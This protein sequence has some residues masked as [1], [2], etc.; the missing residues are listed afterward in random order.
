MK[1]VAFIT[2]SFHKIT[3]SANIYAEEIFNKAHFLVTYF[4][5]EDWTLNPIG[6]NETIIGYDLVV[7]TQLISLEILS[8]IKCDNVV[9]IPMYDFSYTWDIFKWLECINLKILS[10]TKKIHDALTTMGL[11]SYY[12]KYYPEPFAYKPGDLK[13]IFLWQ[14][15]NTINVKSTLHLLNNF[16]IDQIYLHKAID[17]YQTFVEP[18]QQ[19]ISEYN[20]IFSDW[21]E[22]KQGYIEIL[23]NIGIY[24]APRLMEGGASAFIDAMKMGKVVIAN[25]DAAMNEY[26]THNENGLLYDASCIQPI[27]F[28]LIDLTQIQKNAYQSVKEGRNTWLK[29]IP[30]IL[31][32]I[33][34]KSSILLSSKTLNTIREARETLRQEQIILTQELEKLNH[35]KW[36]NFGKLSHQEKIKKVFKIICNPLKIINKPKTI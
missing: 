6:L 13:K 25:D 23:K 32:F 20:I 14:R 18:S 34:T 31:D 8:K 28:K 26:I 10:P 4:Y 15:V 3:N 7:I 2:H 22:N 17:P 9:F 33:E 27:D 5:I 36:Y 19:D 29:S 21:F 30:N 1:R 35:D 24:M 12:I 16:P 11:N